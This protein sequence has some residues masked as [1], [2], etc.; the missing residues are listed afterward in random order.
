MPERVRSDAGLTLVEMLVAIAI[1]GVIMVPLASGIFVGLRATSS[2][3]NRLVSSMDAQRL[4]VYFPPDVQSS[5]TGSTSFSCSGANPAI[6]DPKLQLVSNAPPGGTARTVVYWVRTV[7]GT[8]TRYELVRSLWDTTNCTGNPP[9]SNVVARNIAGNTSADV[10]AAPI[11]D[12]A[13]GYTITVK[14]KSGTND[15][16]YQFTVTGKPRKT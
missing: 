12:I 10:S 1:L 11:P 9:R 13:G 16:S 3:T 15:P 6:T 8:P 4:S 7:A 14:E 2:T 5:N